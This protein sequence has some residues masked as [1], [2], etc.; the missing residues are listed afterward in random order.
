MGFEGWTSA[1][2][3]FLSWTGPPSRGGRRGST[4]LA[5]SGPFEA[6]LTRRKKDVRKAQR[7]RYQVFYENGGATP[8]RTARLIRRDICPLD[9]FCDHLIVFDRSA[10]GRRDEPKPKAVGVYRLLRQEIA[11]RGP[12]FYSAGEFE[13]APLLARHPDK[14]FLEIGRSCVLADYRAKRVIELLWRGLHAYIKAHRVDVLF[15][16]ASLAGSD[17]RAHAP[18]L[19]FLH[20]FAGARREWRARALADRFVPM[21][22]L[23]KAAVAPRA[24]MSGLPPLIKGYLRLGAQI[25][26]GAVID[27]AFGTTDVLIVMPVA[28]LDS[29]YLSYFGSQQNSG[30]AKS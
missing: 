24:A 15:G 23:D 9:R 22:A 1:S 6:R 5:T 19:A 30:R 13:I 14:R 26:E 18:Q 25:G 28:E 8:D 16:C 4:V 21:D 10:R 3:A 7:L 20:H 29:R 17:P 2:G 27:E 12:G 11:E